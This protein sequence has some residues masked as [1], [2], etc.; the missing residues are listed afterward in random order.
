MMRL[1][2]HKVEWLEVLRKQEEVLRVEKMTAD[3]AL[4]LG[5]IMIRL[6]KEEYKK[7]AALRVMIGGQT[8]FTFL[9]EGTSTLNEWWMN[10]KLN[11][12]RATGFSSL[13]SLLEVATGNREPDPEF[14]NVE[15]YALCGGCFP[16]RRADGHL[17]G[18]ALCSG[19]PHQKDHQ[20]LADA[21]CEFLKVEA[22]R[23]EGEVED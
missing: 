8:T 13:R 3:D 12:S 7:P 11:T 2:G 22:P 16:L 21:L 6:A 9:M 4:A 14:D 20:L 10:K 17:L 15:D 1:H 19:L 5:M 18:Y 23:V